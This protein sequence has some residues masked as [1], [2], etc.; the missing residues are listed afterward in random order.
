MKSLK[1]IT[2]PW[3]QAC[4]LAYPIREEVFIREQGVPQEL[5]L[6][7]QDEAAMHALAYQNGECVGTARLVNLGNQSMQIGR[8]A[9]LAKYRGNGIGKR[10]LEELIQLA[11]TQ[12]ASSIILHAQI[13]AIAFYEKLGFVPQGPVY[14]EAGIPHRNMILT[15]PNSLNCPTSL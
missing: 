8:M 6:D 10:I 12:G 1:I 13:T 5:E 4:A 3:S 9:V 2:L 7:E 15:L 11:R 14:P